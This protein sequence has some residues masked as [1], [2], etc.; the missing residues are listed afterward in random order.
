MA[1]SLWQLLTNHVNYINNISIEKNLN[2]LELIDALR[3]GF[4]KPPIVP[5]RLHY[6][7][8]NPAKHNENTLLIMSAWNPG[9]QIGIKIVTV[10]PEN[11]SYNLESINGLYLLMN[12]VTGIP[13]A[14]LDAKP[15]TNWRTACA[16]A[17]ASQYL[18]R[19]DSSTLLLI[20]TGTLATYLIKAHCSV[21]PIKKV[22]IWGRNSSKAENIKDQLKDSNLNIEVINKIKDGITQADIVCCATL[23]ETPLIFGN[24]LKEG[25]H[26]DL[27]GAYK[28]NMREVDDNTILSG[29][30]YVDNI[31]MAP[32]ETGDLCIPISQGTISL[33]DIKGDLFDLCSNKIDGR[34]SE[35]SITIFKSVG[36]ALEDLIAANLVVNNIK[37]HE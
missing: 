4:C 14:I 17:L 29:D 2:Y 15:I 23:S 32:K 5:S 10:A 11:K 1:K 27:I 6:S 25:Q 13:Q 31:E 35:K 22:L 8:D 18:S 37:K 28:P 30:I 20:G 16:S 34:T 9:Q 3:N 36:H 7:I 26:L 21:R 24:D 19:P 12:A 33:E